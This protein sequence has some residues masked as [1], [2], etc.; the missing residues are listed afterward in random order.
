[1]IIAG[2]RKEALEETVHANPGM[3]AIVFD[4]ESADGIREFAAK[5]TSAYPKLNVL[6]NNAG[7]MRAEN[8]LA[9]Q[10]DLADSEAIIQHKSS[11]SHSTDRSVAATFSGASCSN[12]Y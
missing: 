1:M 11:G 12:N 3:Q 9:Q 6:I 4:V 5:I 10:A 7:I 2:R 8:L